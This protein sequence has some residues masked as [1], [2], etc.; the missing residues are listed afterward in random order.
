MYGALWNSSVCLRTMRRAGFSDAAP[1]KGFQYA[2]FKKGQECV[3]QFS[4]VLVLKQEN[5]RRRLGA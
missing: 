5:E 2:L 1:R 3:V 4:Q